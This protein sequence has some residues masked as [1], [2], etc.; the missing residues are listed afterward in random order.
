MKIIKIAIVLAW[1]LISS[2]VV[3]LIFKRNFNHYQLYWSVDNWCE[4]TILAILHSTWQSVLALFLCSIL[5]LFSHFVFIRLAFSKEIHE[6]AILLLKKSKKERQL[7]K[8]QAEWIKTQ[9]LKN[10]TFFN[11]IIYL[12]KSKKIL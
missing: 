12:I 4:D 1:F 6:Y 8:E 3:W 7:V 11:K 2:I 5:A 10:K 9:S